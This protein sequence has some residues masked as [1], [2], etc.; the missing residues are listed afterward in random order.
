MK[1]LELPGLNP[2]PKTKP[3]QVPTPTPARTAEEEPFWVWCPPAFEVGLPYEHP[4]FPEK[5]IN[6]QLLVKN[7]RKPE[8]DVG[9]RLYEAYF[10]DELELR[11]INISREKIR[12][13]IE[14]FHND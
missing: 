10:L 7:C 14:R 13:I 11:K 8:T 9:W 4:D 3:V 1:T 6:R 2:A 12:K 5:F